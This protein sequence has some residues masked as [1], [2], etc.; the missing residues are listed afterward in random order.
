MNNN[1]QNIA[2]LDLSDLFINFVSESAYQFK[3]QS[4]PELSFY[5]DYRDELQSSTI[6]KIFEQAKKYEMSLVDS[7]YD[8]LASNFC[9]DDSDVDF[10]KHLSDFKENYHEY[11]DEIVDNE[12]LQ[13]KLMDKFYDSFDFDYGIEQLLNNSRPEDLTLYFGSDWD[14]DYLENS[15]FQD[16][17]PYENDEITDEFIKECEET[18]I[19]WLVKTQGYQ[20]KDIFDSEK[21]KNSK[22]LNSVFEELY[23]Y[24]NGL[25]GMQLVAI[26]DSTN[27]DAIYKLY[28]EN[29][30]VILKAGTYFGLFNSV[31]GS[32]SGLSIVIEKDILIDENSKL[33]KVEIARKNSSYNYSPDSVYGLYRSSGEELELV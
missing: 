10:Y 27:W 29:K 11:C 30:G 15:I 31:H 6:E 25:E 5:V 8:W 1:K 23:D 16:I 9:F 4:K 18:R 17:D 13:D 22:F 2:T 33:Y 32:G 20:V 26:P 7:V 19:G 28:N 24:V 12:I 14:D 21:R 3:N